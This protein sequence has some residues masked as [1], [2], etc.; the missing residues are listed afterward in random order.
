MSVHRSFPPMGAGSPT[1]QM[2]RED[3]RS[4]F[5]AFP[6]HGGRRQISTKG[7]ELPRWSRDGR[8][9]FYREGKVVMS[10]LVR[11]EGNELQAEVPQAIVE[12]DDS[13]SGSF[14]WDVAPDGKRF[15]LIRDEDS[16]GP[17]SPALLKFTVHW[18]E[19][20]KRLVPRK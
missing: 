8:R 20:L 5:E 16:V 1:S 3:M 19:E 18:F 11:T 14:D 4:M 6:G 17:A 2:N 10:V 15:V 7:G 12:M 9:L 13:D